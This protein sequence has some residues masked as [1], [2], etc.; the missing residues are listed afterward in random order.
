MQWTYSPSR[1]PTA[2]VQ[3]RVVQWRRACTAE[4]A[5]DRPVITFTFDDFPKSALNGAD[6]EGAD[7][8]TGTVHD[9]H[10]SAPKRSE[11][12]QQMSALQLS[13]MSES[14]RIDNQRIKKELRAK[15]RFPLVVD[16]VNAAWQERNR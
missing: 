11:A 5:P 15:L 4:V 3:R 6:G 14:R 16:G 7:G 13:F 10:G 9:D 12:Q 1:S 2:K 8:A